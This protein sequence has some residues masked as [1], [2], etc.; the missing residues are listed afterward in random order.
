[1]LIFRKI[2][3]HFDYIM[4]DEYQDSNKIQEKI[5]LSISKNKN[6]CVVGDEDQSIYRFRGASAENILNFSKHFGE[7]EC[8]L[9]VLE[10]NYRSV[11]DIVEFNN[12]WINAI[13]WHG[14]RFEKYSINEIR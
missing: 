7:G 13:D 4:V 12:K 6:I 2:N 11:N 9:I 5:L 14:N 8:K 1:M 3:N 10:E